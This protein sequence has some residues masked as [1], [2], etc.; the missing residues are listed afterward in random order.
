[1]MQ[2]QI[3]II[4]LSHYMIQFNDPR[5][6]SNSIKTLISITKL[7]KNP[8]L[9]ILSRINSLPKNYSIYLEKQAFCFSLTR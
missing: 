1:M 8:E 2:Q 5:F 9:T 4:V 6:V 3:L 7:E